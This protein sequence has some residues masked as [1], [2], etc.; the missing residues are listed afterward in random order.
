VNFTIPAFRPTQPPVREVKRLERGVDHSPASSSKVEGGV[1]SYLYFP[2][3][4]S[5]TV[6]ELNLSKL[7]SNLS[8][9][10]E[11]ADRKIL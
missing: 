3:G 4:P 1:E 9:K 10:W 5:W 8:D 7:Y 2:S 6:P 11:V